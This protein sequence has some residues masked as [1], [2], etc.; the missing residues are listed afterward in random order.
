MSSSGAVR[1]TR[2][3]GGICAALLNLMATVQLVWFYVNRVPS[4]LNLARFQHGQERTPFQFRVLMMLPLHWAH[5][6]HFLSALAATLTGMSTWFPVGVR[7]EGIMQAAIDLASGAIAGLVATRLYQA[8]SRTGLLTPFVYPLA[9]VMIAGTYCLAT[10]HHF[11]FVYDLPSVGL[12]S[13]GLYLVY[14]RRSPWLFAMLFV[15]ATLNRE[16][17]LFLLLF[18]AISQCFANSQEAGAQTFKWRRALAPQTLCVIL[19]L[20]GFWLAWHWWVV[21]HFAGNPTESM[22]RVWLNIGLLLWPIAWPQM[23]G[24]FGYL[25]PLVLMRRRLIRDARLRAWRWTLP[26]WFAMMLVY[27]IFLEVRIF[28][29]LIP[30]IAGLAALVG[31]E[32]I[33]ARLCPQTCGP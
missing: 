15:V 18:F 17:S 12:F 33:C 31:E 16:V 2:G 27:G 1:E 23:A 21:R 8:S 22:S 11:R 25:L 24:V 10:I 14:F 28:G 6:S 26:A 29:E 4:Y 5:E 9:L 32:V 30:Y 3:M 7:P 20:S 19:P 13:A